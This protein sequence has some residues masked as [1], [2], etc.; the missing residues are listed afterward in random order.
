M[1]ARESRSRD[2]VAMDPASDSA[3]QRLE[4]LADARAAFVA[5][6]A[7]ARHELRVFERDISFWDLD[8]AAACGALDAFL[9]SSQYARATLIL[10]DTSALEGR[11]VR[12]PAIIERFA[13]RLQV[14]VTDPEIRSYAL[15]VT[16]IDESAIL[17]RPHFDR[18]LAVLDRDPAAVAAGAKLFAELLE[19]SSAAPAPRAT[20][21]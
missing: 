13:P 6:V 21:L 19:R 2:T 11:A 3:Y 7:G 15:G 16:I 5:E 8:G 20:G 4:G 14:R 18:A 10:H 17:R 9:R 12:L 1:L